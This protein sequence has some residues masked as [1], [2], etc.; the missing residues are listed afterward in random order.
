MWYFHFDG[1]N[2]I[3]TPTVSEPGLKAKVHRQKEKHRLSPIMRRHEVL[4]KTLSMGAALG[5]F[6]RARA[7]E[8]VCVCVCVCTCVCTCV[9]VYVC[10]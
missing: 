5:A 9:C 2:F 7:S 3:C 6:A 4:G 1:R 8:R 10:V